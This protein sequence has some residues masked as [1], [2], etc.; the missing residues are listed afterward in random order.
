MLF[1]SNYRIPSEIMGSR[2][3]SKALQNPNVAMFSRYHYG[4]V[5]SLIESLKDINPKNLKTPEGR[6]HF[7]EGADTMLAIG[8]GMAALYPI[9]DA[10]AEA[11]FG[12]GAEQRRAGPYH[13]LHAGEQ[14]LA[15]KK[16]LSY[17]LFPVFTFNPMLLA[18][19]ELAL[20]KNLFTGKPIYH[21]E[22]PAS[23]IASDVAT[24]G[25]K[26]VPQASALM[27]S[28]G[29]AWAARQLDI[30]VQSEAQ[31][32]SAERA[33]RMRQRNLKTRA[34][35]RLEGTYKP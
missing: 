1:R 17:M 13:L 26:K 24:Y 20:N 9:M 14:V 5:K 6:K 32:R 30:K 12:E 23:D 22:D 33:E 35:K 19:M 34:K 8:F 16:D 28:G 27:S 18:T 3:L 31:R 11:V 2:M 4:M 29:E 10:V 15:G 7:R 21:P 25:A